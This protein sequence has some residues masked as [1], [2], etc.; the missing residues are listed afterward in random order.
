M[1]KKKEFYPKPQVGVGDYDG[2]GLTDLVTQTQNFVYFF[3]KTSKDPVQWERIALEKPEF[4]QW[5]GRPVAFGDVNGDGR[6]DVVGALIHNDGNLPRDKA[7]VFWIENN[8]GSPESWKVYPLKWSDGANTRRQY[9]GEK[10]DHTLM[11]D[12]DRDGDLDIVGNVEEHYRRVD[13]E[14]RSVFSVVWF[15]NPGK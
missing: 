5:I 8:G 3:R 1:W 9:V 13:G 12:V 4:I 7:S 15:E 11:V 10:W 14:R 6:L 2:D